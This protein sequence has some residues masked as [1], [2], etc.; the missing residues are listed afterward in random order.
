MENGRGGRAQPAPFFLFQEGAQDEK[1]T[2]S[3]GGSGSDSAP[4]G[5]RSGL[6][7]P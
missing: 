6:H 4:V 3:M 1:K 7:A 5:V 2:G